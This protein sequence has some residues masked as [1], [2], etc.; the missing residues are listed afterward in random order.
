MCVCDVA[1]AADVSETS[2][3]QH[4]RILRASKAVPKRRD[5]RVVYDALAHGHDRMLIDV[6]LELSRHAD[7]ARVDFGAPPT[8]LQSGTGASSPCLAGTT[9]AWR[10]PDSGSITDPSDMAE[11]P[12][13]GEE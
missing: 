11:R 1:A 5:G 7:W 10:R 13:P 2:A 3:S 6:A 9:A 4:R 12:R 8:C